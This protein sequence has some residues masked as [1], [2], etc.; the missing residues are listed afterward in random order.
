MT[1]R[2][3][4][5]VTTAAALVFS[6]SMAFSQAQ[7]GSGTR[8]NGLNQTPSGQSSQSAAGSAP[9]AGSSRMQSGQDVDQQVSQQLR[10][11]ARDPKTASDKLFVLE[12]AMGNQWEIEFG[13]LAQQKGQNSQVKQLAQQIVQD[14]QKAND[15]LKQTAQSLN[16]Q[17][18]Q[19][20]PEDKQQK[21]QVFGSLSPEDFDKCYVTMMQ[22]DHAKDLIEYRAHA[23][24]SKDQGVKS[25][26]QQ[27]L[28]A[29]A[30]HRDHTMQAAM[31]LGLPASGPDAIPASGRIEGTSGSTGGSS[32]GSMGGPSGSSNNAGSS[33]GSGAGSR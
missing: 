22:A 4:S 18:P 21:L 19:G 13:R 11:I 27:Q 6:T 31:A 14:H 1:R 8:E 2:T 7:S 23:M 24:D 16:V 25:Y 3:T 29:L 33:G 30:M 26:A 28:P 10:E 12:A 32:S 5:I 20:L 17:L 15:Q 9:M